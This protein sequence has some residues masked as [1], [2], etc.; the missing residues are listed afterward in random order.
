M[1]LALLSG[2]EDRRTLVMAEYTD[3]EM[4]AQISVGLTQDKNP[5]QIASVLRK[6]EELGIDPGAVEQLDNAMLSPRF[7]AKG[8]RVGTLRFLGRDAYVAGLLRNDAD[9]MDEVDASLPVPKYAS[10]ASGDGIRGAIGA[11]LAQNYGSVLHSIRKNGYTAKQLSD[12]ALRGYERQKDG[13]F[14]YDGKSVR[15][16]VLQEWIT[17][18]TEAVVR[19]RAEQ[20]FVR[21]WKK[22][23]AAAKDVSRDEGF[24]AGSDLSWLADPRLTPSQRQRKA[25][26]AIAYLERRIALLNTLNAIQP[27]W[28]SK[29][30][31]EL[32]AYVRAAGDRL[33]MD[34]SDFKAEELLKGG[35]ES[36]DY[37]QLL[38][39]FGVVDIVR[40]FNRKTPEELRAIGRDSSLEDKVEKI[41]AL[42]ALADEAR[43]RTVGAKIVQ[44][45]ASSIPFIAEIMGTGGLAT[46]ASAAGRIGLRPALTGLL[47]NAGISSFRSG[48]AALGRK[49]T[50]TEL[51]PRAVRMIGEAEARRLPAYLPKSA[52]L[53]KEEGSGEPF[54][55]YGSD[56]MRIEIPAADFDSY[57][58]AFSRAMVNQ[59]IE[60]FTEQAGF[61]F[62]ETA[63]SKLIPK[64]AKASIFRHVLRDLEK[65]PVRYSAFW[66][67]LRGINPVDGVVGEYMEEKLGDAIR[68]GATRFAEF[69][70][71]NALN[72]QQDAIFNSVEDEAVTAGVVAL[73]SS[74]MGSAR[75]AAMPF[76]YRKVARWIDTHRKVVEK[77]SAIRAAAT[78]PGIMENFVTQ[79]T[80]NSELF[81]S[82]EDAQVFRQSA[83]EFA[84]AI[85]L[86]D[87]AIEAFGKDGRLIPVSEAKL[88]VAEAGNPKFREAGES[89]LQKAVLPGISG[90]R[91][92]DILGREISEEDLKEYQERIRKRRQDLS[93]RVAS[94]FEPAKAAGIPGAVETEKLFYRFLQ[95]INLNSDA[96]IDALLD[97]FSVRLE[98]AAG[99]ISAATGSAGVSGTASAPAE[100]APEAKTET[101]ASAHEAETETTVSAHEIPPLAS[102]FEGE[103]EDFGADL[104][105]AVSTLQE[106][107][108]NPDM[109]NIEKEALRDIF[110]VSLA[111]DQAIRNLGYASIDDY[112]DAVFRSPEHV[113]EPAEP[114]GRPAEETDPKSPEEALDTIF[115][116][117]KTIRDN[118]GD[119]VRFGSLVG[120]LTG[121]GYRIGPDPELLEREAQEE[122]RKATLAK[123]RE[124]ASSEEVKTFAKQALSDALK[125]VEAQKNKT[126][127][128]SVE[129]PEAERDPVTA[130]RRLA[131]ALYNKVNG[132]TFRQSPAG[133][134][135]VEP[136]DVPILGIDLRDT[137]AIRKMLLEHYLGKEVR[138][139]SDGRLVL[140][141]GKGLRDS[142]KVRGV[143][144]K[145][146]AALD[147]AIESSYPVGYEQ[148]DGLPKHAGIKGQF[149]YAALLNISNGETQK[150]YIATIK[151][152]EPALETET[153]A[154]FK[155]ITIEEADALFAS[156]ARRAGTPFVGLRPSVD[157]PG[158][159]RIR[160]SVAEASPSIHGTQ[161]KTTDSNRQTERPGRETVRHST[162]PGS[163]RIAESVQRIPDAW[164]QTANSDRQTERPVRKTVRHSTLPGSV[165]IAE[166]VQ[167]IP[168][169]WAQT[170]NS[171]RKFTIQQVVDF[172]KRKFADDPLFSE[173]YFQKRPDDRGAV[174]FANDFDR[175]YKAVVTLFKS[176]ADGSTL[177]HE[178]AH[179][180]YK[181][182]E[183]LVENGQANET[184][185]EDFRKLNLWLDH[186]KYKDKD[187]YRERMEFFARGFEAYLR[188]GRAPD[189]G[190]TGVF[191]TMKRLLMNIY[192][193]VRALNVELNDDV[194]RVFDSILSA[195]NIVENEAGVLKAIQEVGEIL[196]GLS[197]D[198]R[199]SIGAIALEAR[200]RAKE[201]ILAEREKRM[202][203]LRRLW[204]ADANTELLSIPLYR[205]WTAI[206][207]A[208]GLDGA[209]VKELVG[210]G[211]AAELKRRG[212]LARKPGGAPAADYAAEENFASAEEMLRS[213]AESPN[214]REY[215]EK[216]LRDREKDFDDAEQ[217]E[218]IGVSTEANIALID[219]IVEELSVRLNRGEAQLSRA[220][221]KAEA[222]AELAEWKLKDLL[223]ESLPAT[224]AKQARELLHSLKGKTQ[225]YEEALR[226]ALNLRK[227]I[228]LAKSAARLRSGVRS[229]VNA[230]KR[231]SRAKRD[232]VE[233]R[234]RGA[235]LDLF[236]RIGISER[237]AGRHSGEAAALIAEQ[238]AREDGSV[239]WE[240]YLG[241]T[242]EAFPDMTLERFQRVSEFAQWL[243]G[244]GRD[245]IAEEKT[246]FRKAVADH[247]SE[248][249]KT[250]EA[251]TRRYTDL[252]NKGLWN[253]LK[254]IG[255]E[256]RFW[257]AK[258]WSIA[259]RADGYTNA[260]S[261]GKMGPVERIV[262]G[263]SKAVSQYM[264]LR[265]SVE[266]RINRALRALAKTTR[267]LD[268]LPAFSGSAAEFGYASWTQE[269][270]IAAALNLGNETN[271]QRLRDGYGWTEEDLNTIAERLSPEDWALI[272]E[273]W[274][275]L[276]KSELTKKTQETFRAE[277]H[278]SLK[279]VE[280]TPFRVRGEEVAG[281]YYPLSYLYR[282]GRLA[283]EYIPKTTPE[284][285]HG[286]VS[287]VKERTEGD[288]TVGPVRLELG[289]LTE[290]IERTAYYAA[291]RMEMR[292]ALGVILDPAFSASFRRTQSAEAYKAFLAL[293][294]YA[295]NPHEEQLGFLK[296]L[297]SWGRGVMTSSALMGSVS[298]MMMQLGGL[299]IGADEL[300]AFYVQSLARY[301][302]NPKF[303]F[304]TAREKSA[305]IRDRAN[306]MDIDLR[307]G[308]RLFRAS[309]SSE[310]LRVL[311]KWGYAGMRFLDVQ[312]SSVLWDAAY[313]KRLSESADEADAVAYADDFVAR[314]QGAARTVDLSP[315]QLTEFGR[316]LAPFI[317]AT[318]AAYNILA[319]S[320]GAAWHGSHTSVWAAVLANALTPWIIPIL[321]RG[322][323]AG[324]DGDDKDMLDRRMQAMIREAITS[325][326]GGIPILRD[327]TDILAGTVS[328][329]ITGRPGSIRGSIG[330]GS[331][332][333]LADAVGDSAGALSSAWDGDFQ[334]ALYKA[335]RA[336]G[337][338]FRLPAVQIYD[339]ARK[340]TNGWGV[341]KLPD[342]SGNDDNNRKRR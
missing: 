236:N 258:L 333:G 176:A 192:R 331:F 319:N 267:N 164:A 35:I 166:S 4:K 39:L 82:P 68:Y 24:G 109:L 106:E 31:A 183:S 303:L 341:D 332:G 135:P 237:E 161:E 92:E 323:L 318:N 335:A 78:N 297:E 205:A 133:E 16:P 89:F 107:V 44:G 260:G 64:K 125:R 34:F 241:N 265:Q 117:A 334:K 271:R 306:F 123:I 222:N 262:W 58:E 327:A 298:T 118:P 143:H 67:G 25:D 281:G 10:F 278:F 218:M 158:G 51:I 141:T 153:R 194:R 187:D 6:S 253:T 329:K 266:T 309:R 293:A 14:L 223:N 330:D 75:A 157:P 45:V 165:R 169:A 146:F 279:M 289:A 30:T 224:I 63:I 175:S 127:E 151:L 275:S 226:I 311:R 114:R 315:F 184:M 87:E 18:E 77:L 9:R 340:I 212:L 235:L 113:P 66:K 120:V 71:L 178:C 13:G 20:W 122:A 91:M 28:N 269:M 240:E 36:V 216:Y 97:G 339:R 320:T 313:R 282:T 294:K 302:E 1:E 338:I 22:S 52:A 257:T 310:A 238:N 195:E 321:I 221:L 307:E 228:E 171:D 55:Y 96:D 116:L 198:D 79:T 134:T 121:T 314:T 5:E 81:I 11:Y 94:V 200:E 69:A 182:M 245:E 252:R 159:N 259:R 148:N 220:K 264:E 273:I 115:A 214:P 190:L 272:Q 41:T 99:R 33:G 305:L 8:H 130:S 84:D 49:A 246:A 232:K 177:P 225:D 128:E 54:Y 90:S 249:V 160:T 126:P 32:E 56:G 342:L 219:R 2:H 207:K 283:E 137:A 244:T 43:G 326:F 185:T 110:R 19:E 251:G 208:G 38:N 29:G 76:H 197:A 243:Y 85:G 37:W 72:F 280:P 142:L 270:L 295:A 40:A 138:I 215:V 61:F 299:T 119:P 188:E 17:G 300:G 290:H 180:L 26:A 103:A 288:I 308:V 3:E 336:A 136:V 286:K 199:S 27:D 328:A 105:A 255:R 276:G 12:L 277:N 152:D 168:D 95:Y 291:C 124:G 62:P 50:Y 156:D 191:R 211:V 284:I 242:T 274:D 74:L 217:L 145:T 102:K 304:E 263:M 65:D 202:R 189:L 47:R 287:S 15:E 93:A 296:K 231:M 73:Q 248:C 285:L 230:M 239:E 104:E 186:Q 60:N 53:A 46:V 317:T 88:S 149:I 167:R 86:T 312:V 204:T 173:T 174:T 139:L 42:A 112:A 201:R 163:V 131:A 322:L 57:A 150:P 213:L 172:V 144:R 229:A 162:S 147:K 101:T 21:E 170:A 203:E 100:K 140:F 196:T 59:Y 70:G 209:E 154:Y 316:F 108:E 132:T 206:R 83:P 181:M 210:E 261:S 254:S 292:H 7:E 111:A 23:V 179:W 234:Y 129:L 256:G 193:S 233:E 324:G 98:E 227:N 250:M 337:A 268:N 247:V 80:G 325:P 48:V 301:A 155:N